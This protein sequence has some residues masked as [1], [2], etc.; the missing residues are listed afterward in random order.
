[1][2]IAEIEKV[3]GFEYEIL[4]KKE[5]AFDARLGMTNIEFI[6]KYHTLVASLILVFPHILDKNALK[7]RITNRA[8]NGHV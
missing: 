5:I 4:F 7:K 2:D 6:K 1:M 8:I 3:H